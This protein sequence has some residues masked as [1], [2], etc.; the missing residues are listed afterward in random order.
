M[1]TK[2]ANLITRIKKIHSETLIV[3]G[4]IILAGLSA[5]IGSSYITNKIKKSNIN[6]QN[7]TP[8][9][10][11]E[12]P[13][14]FPDYDAIKGKNPN[15]KIKV[16]KFTDGCPEKG[17][18]NS[19][20]AVDDFD[21]IKHDYKVVGNIKRAYLYIEAA[22]DYDRPLSIYDTFYFSL[23][24]QGGHLSIKDNLLAVPPSEISRYLYD[25]R[26]ISYSY[27]DKQFKNI[28]FLNLLQDKTVFN[29]HTAV[30]SDRP[31]RVLKEVSIYYQCLDDTLCSIDK[32]K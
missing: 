7:Q 20:S 13:S 22:V 9:P 21:G 5:S 11:I 23:R 28:N 29:I 25:L 12:K 17:C 3:Y 26:S 27:K 32:I 2:I 10:Q 6:A 15:S 8:P 31:G 24:Y 30:S 14:E 1:K 18:V 4:I 19:K 16:V